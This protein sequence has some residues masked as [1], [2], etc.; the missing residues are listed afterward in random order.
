MRK[1]FTSFVVAL[2]FVFD[3]SGR[4]ESGSNST[5]APYVFDNV[6]ISALALGLEIKEW[7]GLLKP[8][9]S[10]ELVTVVQGLPIM[11]LTG[12][13]GKTWA[14]RPRGATQART[15]V[16][17]SV[18]LS[19]I[20][21]SVVLQ[22]LNMP[23]LKD[24]IECMRDAW[25]GKAKSECV[26]ELAHKANLEPDEIRHVLL[27]NLGARLISLSP[28]NRE[29]KALVFSNTKSADVE[30]ALKAYNTYELAKI[31]VLAS[32][33]KQSS[34]TL[35]TSLRADKRILDVNSNIAFDILA[36]YS[37]LPHFRSNSFWPQVYSGSISSSEGEAKLVS[38]GRFRAG[39]DQIY[40]CF[41][42]GDD[43]AVIAG[44]LKASL[45]TNLNS[46]QS[47]DNLLTTM[48]AETNLCLFLSHPGS[49]F[50]RMM[51]PDSGGKFCSFNLD[52]AL[53]GKIARQEKLE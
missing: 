35:V 19:P 9:P 5:S 12:D 50:V 8:Q 26:E 25:E 3:R 20:D 53:V 29:W 36:E 40:A 10:K 43:Y 51:R 33:A 22:I 1:C 15:L 39:D 46:A 34:N 21:L 31:A 48:Q 17:Q 44:N 13:G 16:G 6:E 4:S 32:F 18:Q 24:Y 45:A 38:T 28:Q 49:A 37:S 27:V 52:P 14:T 7:K 11:L 41:F 30:S 2:A 23:F 42:S 47:A